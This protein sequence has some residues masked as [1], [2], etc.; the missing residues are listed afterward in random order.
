MAVRSLHPGVT[1]EEVQA[2]TGWRLPTPEVP[3]TT[4]PPTDEELRL[5]REELDPKGYYLRA[6]V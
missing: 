5:L 3:E 6:G 1:F 4:A 2:N